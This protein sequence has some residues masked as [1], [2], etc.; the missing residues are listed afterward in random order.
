MQIC[1][2]PPPEPPKLY[3]N[4]SRTE[5]I[6]VKWHEEGQRSMNV[7]RIILEFYEHVFAKLLL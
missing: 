2:V 1:P 7:L 5:E 4:V 3:L 6:V